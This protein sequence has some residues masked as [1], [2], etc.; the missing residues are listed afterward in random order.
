VPYKVTGVSVMKK[1]GDAW[2]LLKKHES[3]AKALAHLRA[4][5]ANVKEK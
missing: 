5:Y 4:L 1:Q 2:V 3:H